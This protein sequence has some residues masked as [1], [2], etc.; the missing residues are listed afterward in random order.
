M[1]CFNTLKRESQQ[2]PQDLESGGSTDRLGTVV[3]GVAQV[4]NVFDLDA[5]VS[6][7]DP[8]IGKKNIRFSPLNISELCYHK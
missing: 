7:I 6:E 2:N 4:E 8:C 5:K 3:G 1:A